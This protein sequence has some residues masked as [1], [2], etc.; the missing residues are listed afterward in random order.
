MTKKIDLLLIA[1]KNKE[2]KLFLAAGPIFSYYEF[3]WPTKKI[4]KKD[5]LNKIPRP[6]W[7]RETLI[8]SSQK[9]YVIF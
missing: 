7:Y 6:I 9:P 4:L 8:E 2:K 1:Q 3:F 5:F